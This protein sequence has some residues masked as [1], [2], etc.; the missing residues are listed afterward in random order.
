M[1]IQ[2]IIDRRRLDEKVVQMPWFVQQFID[3]KL[4][5][6]SPP[7]CSNM[8]ATMSS[9]SDGC[10]QKDYRRRRRTAKSRSWI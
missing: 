5:D 6:L 10:V 2:K 7:P 9:F 3:Y 8:C 1:N 4:P